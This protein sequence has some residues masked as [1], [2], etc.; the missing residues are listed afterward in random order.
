MEKALEKPLLIYSASAGSGKTYALVKTYLELILKGNTQPQGF[1]KIIA[2]TFT[3]KAAGEIRQRIQSSTG[4]S[5]PYSGTFHSLCARILRIDGQ[6]IGLN[7]DFVIYD[8]DNQKQLLKHIYKERGLENSRFG[9]QAVRSVISQAKNE[10]ISPQQYAEMAQGKYQ[11]QAAQ[12]YAWYQRELEKA[13]AV[14]FDDLL[15]KTLQLL[16]NVPMVRDKY[17]NQ[18]EHVLVDEYQDTNKVQYE[19]TKI[20]TQPHNNLYVV[21]D[22][23]QSI[24]AWRGADYRNM[25]LLRQDFAGITEYRLEQNY[26]SSQTI[27]DAATQVISHNTNHPI[28]EL[29]TTK[30]AGNN[31]NVIEAASGREEARE[32]VKHIQKEKVQYPYSE[33]AILYRTN[34]Q[35]REFEEALIR[36]GIPYRLIGGTKFYERK[37]IKDVISYLSYFVNQMDVVSFARI[38]KLGK[39]RLE[40][41]T[42]WFQ[43]K[44]VQDKDPAG[45]L[46]SILDVTGYL[47]KYNKENEEDLSR[48]EN[49]HELINVAAQFTT[50]QQLLE[51]IA[52]I[53]DDAFADVS[54]KETNNAV[55]LMSLH[56]A[57]G[58]EFEVVFMVGMEDGLMPHSRSMLDPEEM[59]EERRLCYVGITR[60]KS[61]LYL[62]YARSRYQYGSQQNA[63]RSR[64]LGDISEQILH[65]S[66]GDQENHSP[67]NRRYVQIDE[68]L[69]EGIIKGELDL[70][71]FIDS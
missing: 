69:V 21:G 35:S 51:N 31:I 11:E 60:A 27:L 65:F 44:K 71:A 39:R 14:D 19:L 2:M 13:Q 67:T 45:I 54:E 26:R 24:Y 30:T 61:Q 37:E 70:D 43:S 58:L 59:E 8:T 66:G 62:T 57:K 25:L 5:L 6:H 7:R 42:N 1:A 50:V 47:D 12:I 16:K 38:Q 4:F 34:A 17:Q 40:K 23:S 3:N 63:L 20:F 52:L 41:F 15:L 32:V 28:L 49:V 9:L 18:L 55:S 68:N 64:F 36:A 46:K 53:Q 48:I 56:S 10:I 22:F 33:M 29:W